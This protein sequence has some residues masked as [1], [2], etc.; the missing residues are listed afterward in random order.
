VSITEQSASTITRAIVTEIFSS[1]GVPQMPLSVKAKTWHLI[2]SR[3]FAA[4]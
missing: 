4:Y 3:K 2:L 1:H